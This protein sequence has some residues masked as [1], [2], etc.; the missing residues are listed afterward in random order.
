MEAGLADETPM[1][2]VTKKYDG[3]AGT[4][5]IIDEKLSGDSVA[6]IAAFC[7]EVVIDRKLFHLYLRE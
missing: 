1:I 5:I 2:K 4:V 3:N 6:A 7:N